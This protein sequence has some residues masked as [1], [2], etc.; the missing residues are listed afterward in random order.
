MS[1]YL[2]RLLI[3]LI[4]FSFHAPIDAKFFKIPQFI[5][6]QKES[7][8]E[9]L[10][11]QLTIEENKKNPDYKKIYNL[12]KQIKNI[13]KQQPF[14]RI[15]NKIEAE[16]NVQNEAN[17]PENQN[18]AQNEDNAQQEQQNPFIPATDEVDEQDPPQPPQPQH[19]ILTESVNTITLRI[20][21]KI[22]P[23]D[24]SLPSHW[25]ER[26]RNRFLSESNHQILFYKN[27]NPSQISC[28]LGVIFDENTNLT[29]L[30]LY[31]YNH[32]GIHTSPIQNF[33]YP[34]NPINSLPCHQLGNWIDYEVLTFNSSADTPVEIRL[35]KTIIETT[36][37]RF[38]IKQGQSLTLSNQAN[39]TGATISFDTNLDQLTTTDQCG[40]QSHDAQVDNILTLNLTENEI[41]NRLA[42]NPDL[43]VNP[44]VTQ[45]NQN[46]LLTTTNTFEQ[47]INLE[48]AE[49]ISEPICQ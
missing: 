44:Q 28:Y 8:V 47:F 34:Q 21:P 19:T 18:Q 46:Y 29:Y 20:T 30:S 23:L 11:K 49:L 38:K 6:G 27:D 26:S 7:K 14:F 36:P 42:D 5:Q 45:T 48:V 4:I 1:K 43:P 31:N 22:K 15:I 9:K 13:E 33:R 25:Y 10:K 17:Q 41:Q 37:F 3:L 40:S 16:P 12:K 39:N 24:N 35:H 2:S 32:G